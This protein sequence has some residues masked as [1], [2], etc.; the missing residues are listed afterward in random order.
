MAA[1][2]VLINPPYVFPPV[3]GATLRMLAD[4]P[5]VA[6]L[7][8]QPFLYPPAGLLSIGGALQR[9]G[10]NAEGIDCNTT[11]MSM[12]QLAKRCEGAKVVG[13]QLLV[14]N[15][16]SVY[17]LV[18]V[19]QGRGYEIVVGGPY[20]SVHPEIVAKLGLRYGISG[21]GE[22]A[23]PQLCNA[24]VNGV[25]S[26]EDVDGIIVADGAERVRTRPPRLLEDLEH[27]PMEREFIRSPLY[28]QPF[29]GPIEVALTSRGCP[30]SCPFCYC[31]SAS[32]N[33]MFNKS[34][35]VPVDV[36]V[37][38]LKLVV[39][40]YRPRYIEFLD[41]TFTVDR[42][43]VR[44]L[45]D[46]I[47]REG[48]RVEWGAKTRADLLDP[49]LLEVMAR[50]GLVKIGFGLESGSFDLRKNMTKDFDNRHIRTLFDAA[51]RLRVDPACTILF[52]HPDETLADMARSVEMVKDIHAAYV[53]FHIM[54]LIPGT[55]LFK[56][57]L[58]EK[59]VTE[60]VF[61]R[62]MR[63]ECGYPEYAPGNLTPADMR[64]VHRNALREFYL[65]PRYV[66]EQAR[67]ARRPSD[68]LQYARAAQSIWNSAKVDL[69]IW[70][71]G[72]AA[73][74]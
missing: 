32:P 15:A 40:R 53:E 68:L 56:R 70:R 9:A 69:P 34:R 66:A 29:K 7:A 10:F 8:S 24:I 31:S 41:E 44:E 71:V 13:I 16:R 11:P 55:K 4:D 33:S 37:R 25:G 17:Q 26:P 23:F 5:L 6:D 38:D 19:M 46:A 61:D 62:F 2:V 20:P 58:Q 35:W 22:R 45:S 50:A 43:Y 67:R 73:P 1:D 52:G 54:V 64:R 39:N 27:W 63:G 28:R 21:E 49:D 72:R 47:V 14:A 12:E 42:N 18:K 74:G 57:A 30:F 3:D 51:N 36:A 60:D 65:R 59:K 48:I